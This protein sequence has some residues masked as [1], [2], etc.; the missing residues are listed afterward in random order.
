MNGR[1]K[2]KM[3]SI[4]HS[5]FSHLKIPSLFRFSQGCRLYVLTAASQPQ[6]LTLGTLSPTLTCLLLAAFSC[7]WFGWKGAIG[8]L[9]SLI[10]KAVSFKRVISFLVGILNALSYNISISGTVIILRSH[11]SFVGWSEYSVTT[12]NIWKRNFGYKDI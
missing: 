6:H 2:W 12:Y 4:P 11:G 10:S 9:N 5:C 8:S 3:F 1:G 7:C